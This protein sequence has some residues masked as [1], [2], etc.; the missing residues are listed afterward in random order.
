MH[1][2][3]SQN[4]K[5]R[6]LYMKYMQGSTAETSPIPALKEVL[7]GFNF[8]NVSKVFGKQNL[9]I[10]KMLLKRKPTPNYHA[11]AADGFGRSPNHTI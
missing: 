3:K 7:R 8:W 1:Q 4:V 9:S 6:A 5:G 10:M 2:K 11:A